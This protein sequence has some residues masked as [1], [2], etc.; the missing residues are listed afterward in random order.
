MSHHDGVFAESFAGKENPVTGIEARTKIVFFAAALLLNLLSPTVFAP[1]AIAVFCLG[2]LLAIK[3][4]PKLL[5]L[6]LALPL[7]MAAVILVTQVFFYGT[8]PLFAVSPGGWRLVGY[9]EGLAR[10]FLIM[11]RVIGGVSL[12]LFLSLSTPANRLLMAASWLRLPRSFIELTLLVYRYIFVLV[13]EAMAIRDAQRVRLGYRGWR[14]SMRSLGVLG[15][16][17]ILRAYDRAG[18]VFEAMSARGYTGTMSLAYTEPFRRRDLAA[19]VCLGA[20]LGI[21]YLAGWLG[22]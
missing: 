10:G 14:R 17:L 8:T 22:A 13:E 9:E 12:I 6:R 15:G 19:A 1:L 7:L 16:S 11:A 21:F 20:V 18:R 3:I 2:T 4:P 5:L